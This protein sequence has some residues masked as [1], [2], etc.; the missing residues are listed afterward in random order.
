MEKKNSK[1]KKGFVP[2]G[3]NSLITKKELINLMKIG[4]NSMA[5]IY[6]KQGQGSGFFV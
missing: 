2:N 1:I 5:K 3:K 4:E 6:S